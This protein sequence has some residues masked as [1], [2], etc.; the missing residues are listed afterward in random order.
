LNKRRSVAWSLG[1]GFVVVSGFLGLLIW[2][3]LNYARQ[4]PGGND[5]L[6]H[7]VGTRSFLVDGLSPYSDQT[8]LRIQ[9]L[10][11][12]RPALA[13]EHQLRVAYPLYS[14]ILFFPFALFS[15]FTVARAVWMTT[16]E[17]GLILLAILTIQLAG[18]KPNLF[19]LVIFILFSLLW[20][21]AVRPVINGNAVILV[22]LGIV[23]AMLAIRNKADEL[24]GILLALTTIK[25]QVVLVFLIF[26]V[27]WFT[28]NR[29]WRLIAWLIG[30]TLILA[31]IAWF[32]IPDWILQNIREIIMY[33]GYNP[34][35][36]PGVAL[37]TWF[38]AMGQRL[39]LGLT[40]IIMVVLAFEWIVGRAADFRGFLWIA[41]LTL[42]G[43]QWIGIQTD[44]GNFIVCFPTIALVFALID[45]RYRSRGWVLVI[46]IMLL[47]GAGLWV[48][49]V[50]TIDY[51][52][53]QPQQ[54]PIM[55]FPLPALLL[56]LLYWI[57]WWAFHPGSIWYDLV[58]DREN[59]KMR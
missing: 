35:G 44:P 53:G 43:S 48:L 51:S 41:C 2:G 33:P 20:Y 59:P 5:F 39:G 27:F 1:L 14:V 7:W 19:M 56:L 6:V 31:A 28:Y 23:G 11:Y 37:A 13:G 38:P 52:L 26:I 25:P 54:N 42:V 10:A 16:L 55:F 50:E 17:V 15:D 30:T 45:E 8:A 18:W 32:L 58:F 4:N 34:P 3:N 22:S 29:R 57:R 9:T 40:A 49:F 46:L 12:G 36:T 47:I 24:A 21:N